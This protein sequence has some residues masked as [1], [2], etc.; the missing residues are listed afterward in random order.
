MVESYANSVEDNLIDGVSFRLESG[1]S[2]INE[3]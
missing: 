2:Y 3:R 1:A